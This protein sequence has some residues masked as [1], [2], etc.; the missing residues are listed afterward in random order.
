MKVISLISYIAMAILIGWYARQEA[1][2]YKVS[3]LTAMTFFALNPLVLLEGIG[4]GHN[5]TVMLV[6]MTL[7]L[8]LWQRDKWAWAAF[9]LTLAALIKTSGLILMP[10]FGVS[11][12]AAMPDWRARAIRGL[13]I[14]AIFIFMAAVAYRI[15]GPLEPYWN[16]WTIMTVITTPWIFGIPLIGPLLLKWKNSRRFETSP[17][18]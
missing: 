16:F 18:L 1:S 11:V 15:T 8:I 5:D 3:S 7:G 10:L 6:L 12:L 13:G 4:N 17:W 9:A 2:Q 14:A